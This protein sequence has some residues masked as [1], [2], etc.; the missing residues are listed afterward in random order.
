MAGNRGSLLGNFPGELEMIETTR[1]SH[2][3]ISDRMDDPV[4]KIRR[5]DDD[6][7]ALMRPRSPDYDRHTNY[8][9]QEEQ[10]RFR[11]DSQVG[12]IMG[13]IAEDREDRQRKVVNIFDINER[14]RRE[15]YDRA[16]RGDMD[17]RGRMGGDGEYRTSPERFDVRRDDNEEMLEMQL[18]RPLVRGSVEPR[19]GSWN[20]G[21][22][23][24]REQP[25]PYERRVQDIRQ[26]PPPKSHP[27]VPSLVSMMDR[28][29]LPD[30]RPPR[31]PGT[32][33]MAMRDQRPMHLGRDRPGEQP[34]P[35]ERHV[36]ENRQLPPPK[37]CQQ[38]PSLV[39]MMNREFLPDHRQQRMP[40]ADLM[41]MGD[42]TP[43]RLGRDRPGPSVQD[44]FKQSTYYQNKSGN[45]QS[46]RPGN[47]ERESSYSRDRDDRS[48]G[49]SDRMDRFGNFEKEETK[50]TGRQSNQP[51]Q[52]SEQS[53]P[54]SLLLNLSQLLA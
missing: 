45:V 43:K 26:L 34:V 16:G 9:E 12:P 19:M 51:A 47:T 29:F 54:V 36:Q 32:D 4:P 8:M 53:D 31:M 14:L 49:T 11:S 46:G 21:R 7:P 27:Q 20:D 28:E 50:S 25:M 15:N 2:P 33:P 13:R 22:A 44:E 17:Q 39:G 18:G 23:V 1:G 3:L 48:R 10:D 41:A 37:S 24:E 38:V 30:E 52:G 42:Q 6:R 35:Y 5:M 40:A